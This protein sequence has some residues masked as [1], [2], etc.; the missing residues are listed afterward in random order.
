MENLGNKKASFL[1]DLNT[2]EKLLYSALGI[3]LIF[4]FIYFIVPTFSDEKISLAGKCD[5]KN[6]NPVSSTKPFI[7]AGWAFDFNTKKTYAEKVKIHLISLD[8]VSRYSMKSKP[9]ER[10]DVAKAFALDNSAIKSGYGAI[11]SY[12]LPGIYEV[13]IEQKSNDGTKVLCSPGIL[14][15]NK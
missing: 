5:I 7:V 9:F 10:P 1:N 11:F 12:V 13:I 4:G 3:V 6:L 15:V 2:Q 14:T 8:R